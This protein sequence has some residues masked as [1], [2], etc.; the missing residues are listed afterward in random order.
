LGSD[1]VGPTERN[2]RR[3]RAYVE[4][5]EKK[6]RPEVARRRDAKNASYSFVGP[7][8]VFTKYLVARVSEGVVGKES[9][10]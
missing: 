8:R 9:G 6:R 5:F 1:P 3:S 2:R 10:R 4:D 7:K